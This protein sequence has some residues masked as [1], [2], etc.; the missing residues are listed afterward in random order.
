MRLWTA[1]VLATG[2]AIGGC[3]DKKNPPVTLAPSASALAP[4]TPVTSAKTIK[5]TIDPKSATAID[6]PAPKEHIKASTDA[7]AGT[8][9]VDAGNLANSRGEVKMDLATLTMKHFDKAAD[10]AAQTGHA[11]CWLEVADCEDQKLDDKVKADNKYAVYAIRSIDNLSATD[12]AKVAPT[13][14]AGDDVRT[15]TMTTHGDLLIHGR[16]V[17]NKESNVEVA[18]RYAPGDPADKPKAVTIKSK[19]PLKV[20]L[21]QHDVKP[22]DN[23]GKIAKASFHLLGTKVADTA[24]ITLDIRAKP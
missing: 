21:E 8:L 11:R 18:F 2:I 22:R 5:L 16:K 7:A 1:C 19:T 9:E 20:T 12:L 10:D 13:K 14:D 15:V 3:D 23:F 17:E 24:D 4:S 6:M